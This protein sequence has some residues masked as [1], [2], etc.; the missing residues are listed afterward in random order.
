MIFNIITSAKFRKLYFCI[1]ITILFT[2]VLSIGGCYTTYKETKTPSEIA[3]ISDYKIVSATTKTGL[4]LNL[5]DKNAMYSKEFEGQ[6]NVLIYRLL[7]TIMIGENTGYRIRYEVIRLSDLLSVRVERVEVDA[8]LTILATIGIIVALLAIIGIIVLATK[9]SCPF[10]YSYDGEK[11]T[12]DAEP[13]GG[14]ITEGLTRT[15]YSRLEHLKAVDGKYLLLMRNEADE[16]QH[17]DEMK[18]CV[19]DHPANTK[20]TP[21]MNG[22]MVVFDS[23]ISPINVTDERGSNITSFFQTCDGVQWQ[24]TMPAETVFDDEKSRN[25]L[26]FKFPKPKNAEKV[27][28]LINAGTALWGGHMI[29]KMLELRGNKVDNWYQEIDN[30]GLAYRILHN[31]MEREELYSLKMNLNVNGQWQTRGYV[32]A[33]GPFVI[34]DK[35]VELDISDIPGDTLYLKLNPPIGY[36]IIDYV[37]VIYGDEGEYSLSEVEISTAID[38][39]ENNITS[40]LKNIDKKYYDMPDTNSKAYV[41]FKA[42]ALLVGSERSIFLKTTGYYD[43]H[44][45][46]DS[47]EQSALLE[48]LWFNPGYIVKYSLELYIDKLR[49]LGMLV[50]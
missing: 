17:T 36:W 40:L 1:T 20:V 34:E 43:I 14:A 47:P 5:K 29:K 9:E 18:I 6:R 12:F 22:N 30:K 24:S 46:K 48:K 35:I 16:T 42:P 2:F 10:I 3:N 45:K 38:E 4:V 32:T 31:F 11:Y 7:D 28:L 41:Y 8:G 27:K 21:D 26:T 19:V 25:E 49:S 37:G 15:D 44:L 33:G 23:S 39:K 50:H 13:Y